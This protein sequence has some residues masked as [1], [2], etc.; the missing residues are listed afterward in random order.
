MDNS[1]LNKLKDDIKEKDT[2]ILSCSAGPDSMSLLDLL[3]KLRETIDIN[4]ICAHVNHKK[5]IESEEEE[6]FLKSYCEKAN[7]TFELLTIKDIK[8]NFQSSARKQRYEFLSVLQEK[9]GAKVIITAHHADD[10]IETILMKISRG[11]NIKGYAGFKEKI[12]Y[13]SHIILKPLISFTKDEIL[14]Y[15]K[16]NNVEYR[17]DKSNVSD[18]YTRNRYRKHMLPFLKS[19]NCK[20]HE[21]YN[22]FSQKLLAYDEFVKKCVNNLGVINNDKINL[23]KYMD[24]ESFLKDRI[25]EQYIE[26][27][28]KNNIFNTTDQTIY[29]INKLI[30]S[31]NGKGT[32]DLANGFKGIKQNKE[33]YIQK[34]DN[35]L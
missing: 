34:E 17:T 16:L 33:F 1:F 26:N 4:I 8:D 15:N 30:N 14:E 25:L 27:I 21:K 2:V 7:I 11:S 18:D 5:R 28:Q 19:E 29:E 35:V 31:Q 13:D 6:K 12:V 24:V 20:V 23:V 9:Y 22:M 10:L 3:I 32:I